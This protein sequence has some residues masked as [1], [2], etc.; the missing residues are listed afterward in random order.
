[1]T[2]LMIPF[3]TLNQFWMIWHQ[4][5]Y[6]GRVLATN[7]CVVL[8][9]SSQGANGVKEQASFS[10][11]MITTLGKCL[12]RARR[13]HRRTRAAGCTFF[14]QPA[15]RLLLEW[16]REGARDVKSQ[17]PLGK[18]FSFTDDKKSS[19]YIQSEKLKRQ[20]EYIWFCSGASSCNGNEWVFFH[21]F[22]G[23]FFFFFLIS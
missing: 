4:S 3:V 13:P 2:I 5:R 23:F 1:M 12:G 11:Y 22:Y 16:T 20:A 10:L 15:A 6:T 18:Y 7:M 9:Y 17:R 19:Y 21:L 8:E 14:L